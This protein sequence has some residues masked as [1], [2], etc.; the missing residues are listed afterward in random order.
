MKPDTLLWLTP[1]V[2][3]SRSSESV[4]RRFPQNHPHAKL[5]QG[6]VTGGE[7]RFAPALASEISHRVETGAPLATNHIDWLRAELVVCF[8]GFHAET[9]VLGAIDQEGAL[10][11][12]KQA[13]IVIGF[14]GI[15]RDAD[16]GAA[17]LARAEGIAEQVIAELSACVE[18]VAG[19]L[20]HGPCEFRRIVGPLSPQAVRSPAR[21]PSKVA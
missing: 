11:D 3:A 8:A 16:G 15:T 7:S 10:A 18:R 20:S 19:V 5:L 4:G 13:S 12:V 14:L 17:R 2:G 9:R 1:W 6:S 21:H